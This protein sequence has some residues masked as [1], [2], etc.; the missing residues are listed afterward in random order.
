MEY[1]I[2]ILTLRSWAHLREIMT[3]YQEAHGHCL[4]KLVVTQ[5]FSVDEQAAMLGIG[6]YFSLLLYLSR[7]DVAFFFFTVKYAKNRADYFSS[8]LKAA[9]DQS[10]DS[11]IT[12]IMIMRCDVDLKMIQMQYNKKY[13][14]LVEDVY[15]FKKSNYGHAL[16]TLL[17]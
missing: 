12:E 7:I 14:S 1:F 17:N 15:K 10:E 13:S 3:K 8:R 11:K 5:D 16:L 2:C 4:K 6:N 9:F